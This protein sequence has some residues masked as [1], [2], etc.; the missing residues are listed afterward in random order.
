MIDE[1]FC[2][3]VAGIFQ[4]LVQYLKQRPW[5]WARHPSPPTQPVAG[6]GWDPM[7]ST[8]SSYGLSRVVIKIAGPVLLQNN[9]FPV[10]CDFNNYP[11]TTV[12]RVRGV[13]SLM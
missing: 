5:R 7:T 11:A 6:G 10:A 8:V 1:A 13:G 3:G 9:G 4:E 12:P 2:E